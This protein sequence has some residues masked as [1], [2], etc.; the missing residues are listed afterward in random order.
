[1]RPYEVAAR[2]RLLTRILSKLAFVV[3]T[4]TSAL[5][6]A[7]VFTGNGQNLRQITSKSIRLES[8]T[9]DITLGRGPFLFDGTVAGMD[10]ARYDC[11][12]VLENLT[13]SPEEVEVGFPVD[14]EFANDTA[15]KPTPELM[16]DWV[17]KYGLLHSTKTIPIRWNWCVENQARAQTS[18]ARYLFG[19]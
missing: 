13:N 3:F 5:A 15:V 16:Q 19:R 7:G 2:H 4:S 1:M 9:V 6:D 12:F 11:R 14:S 18:S 8:I 17:L 10:E